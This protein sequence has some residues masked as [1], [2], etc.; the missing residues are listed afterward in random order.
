[1]IPV[2]LKIIKSILTNPI[3]SNNESY[4]IHVKRKIVRTKSDLQKIDVLET[5]E[6]GRCLFLDGLIQTAES[7]HTLYDRALLGEMNKKDSRILIL[8]G[9][10]GYVAD[11]ALH[12]SKKALVELVELD[13]KVVDTSIKYLNQ[14]VFDNERLLL[15]LGDALKFTSDKRRFGQYDG[16]VCDLTDM[17]VVGDKIGNREFERFYR[18]II[19]RSSRLLKKG[20][21]ISLQAGASKVSSS[22]VDMVA[23]FK[24]ILDKEGFRNTKRRDVFIPSYGEQVAF[25]YAE[26]RDR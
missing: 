16:I 1:M 17:P 22:Y 11:A 12:K 6:F 4:G 15:H 18:T 9:G 5:K 3:Y 8:G 2:G 7:D 26:N 10:D 24:R 21:W 20:A 13:A 14:K 25:V 23:V 19:K